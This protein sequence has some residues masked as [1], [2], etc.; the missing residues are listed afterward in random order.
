MWG[1]GAGWLEHLL[2]GGSTTFHSIHQERNPLF[3]GMQRPE[4]IPPNIDALLKMVV[5]TG[6]DLGIAT[7]GDADRIGLVD[8]QGNF[9]TQLQV[10]GLL[11]LYLLQVRGQRGPIVKTLNS[12]V[13]LNMLGSKFGVDVFE[14]GTDPKYIGPKVVEVN[15]MLGAAESGGFIFPGLPER[16]SILAA[17]YLLD[18]VVRTGKKPSQLLE[19]LYDTI[20]ARY[21]YSRVDTSFP[22]GQREAIWQRVLD[23]KPTAIMGLAVTSVDTMDGF[24]FNLADG[25]WLL[26][27]FSGTEPIARVYCETTQKDRMKAILDE[28]FR[29]A[30]LRQ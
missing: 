28:G 5:E 12:T 8:E 27:R 21:Y 23:A 1:V 24:K 16:D 6:A 15:A 2:A 30:G 19:W 9:I 20:G 18:M 13:M 25:G 3:P 22:S 10:G 4:P 17:L 7:D 29:I 14:T 26:F 11:A